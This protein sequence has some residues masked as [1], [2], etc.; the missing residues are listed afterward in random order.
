VVGR[1]QA[2]GALF[3]PVVLAEVDLPTGLSYKFTYNIYGELDKVVYPTGGYA[4]SQFSEV[5]PIG[6][7]LPPYSQSNRAV[8][9]RQQS[10]KGDGS[11]TATWQYAV[12]GY[13]NN[14]DADTTVVSTT[15]PDGSY[16]EVR[17]HNFRAP[18]QSG[19]T[20]PHYWPFGFEDA[21]Q[22][23]VY[24]ERMFDKNPSTARCE[25]S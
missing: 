7:L 18:L 21:R 10:P 1:G 9:L 8:T 25:I 23:A 24:E 14:A 2:G 22:G 16:S 17:R 3:D 12:A 19:R 11:D 13:P 6:D 4:Q 15:A 5:Q 20:A